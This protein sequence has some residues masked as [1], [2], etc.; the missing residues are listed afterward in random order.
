MNARFPHARL[1]GYGLRHPFVKAGS[2]A[3]LVAAAVLAVA[4]GSWW[5]VQRADAALAER[6]TAERRAL[7]EARQAG[8]AARNHARNLRDVPLLEAKLAAAADQTRIVDGLARLAR[9]HQVRIVDQGYAARRDKSGLVVE[10][11]VEGA[12]GSVRNFVRGLGTLPLWI[13]VQ[14]AQLD[15]SDGTGGVKGRLRLVSFRG[16]E[17]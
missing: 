6:L 11:A 17:A 13:E 12:Y 15:R 8:E 16:E 10:L 7:V 3:S 4:A 9:A 14:E 1:L 2:V 5:P